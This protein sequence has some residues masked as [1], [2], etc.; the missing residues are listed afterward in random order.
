MFTKPESLS[1]PAGII[2]MGENIVALAALR[3]GALSDNPSSQDG[4]YR[5]QSSSDGDDRT[6]SSD[7][8]DHTQKSGRG[9]HAP[10]FVD[11]NVGGPKSSLLPLGMPSPLLQEEGPDVVTMES[12]SAE[13]SF[14][15]AYVDGSCELAGGLE[16]RQDWDSLLDYGS[17]TRWGFASGTPMGN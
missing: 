1:A 5:R 10:I 7:G 14:Q 9:D 3:V 13:P 12:A 6:Q 11:R 16:E 15:D 4:D 8:A 17:T 2:G